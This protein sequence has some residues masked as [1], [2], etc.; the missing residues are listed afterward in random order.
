MST[1]TMV[2]IPPICGS[3]AKIS[4]IVNHNEP[5]FLPHTN[6]DLSQINSGWCGSRTT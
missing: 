2:N 1:Q 5:V 6:L 4:A 3:E